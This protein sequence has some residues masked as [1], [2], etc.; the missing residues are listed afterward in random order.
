[1]YSSSTDAESISRHLYSVIFY[2]TSPK[3]SC[4]NRPN[5]HLARK[6][7]RHLARQHDVHH[8]NAIRQIIPDGDAHPSYTRSPPPRRRTNCLQATIAHKPSRFSICHSAHYA[9]RSQRIRL[10]PAQRPPPETKKDWRHRDQGTVLL[11]HGQEISPR[12][13]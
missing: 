2:P 5:Y 13:I 9:G 7:S 12:R 4:V 3:A 11:R 6:K 10:H 8:G 1:M